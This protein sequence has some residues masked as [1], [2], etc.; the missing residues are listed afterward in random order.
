MEIDRS[1]PVIPY[2]CEQCPNRVKKEVSKG[3]SYLIV[4]MISAFMGFQSIDLKFN[5]TDQWVFA[6]KEVPFTVVVPGLFLI[7][8]V[9]GLDTSAIAL[10][11]S[12]ALSS[13]RRVD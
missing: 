3:Y 5:K 13:G 12:N 11:I 8:G 4:G 2:G 9:L 1:K 10:G 7:A 6:T